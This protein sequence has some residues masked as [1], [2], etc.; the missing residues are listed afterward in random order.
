MNPKRVV[1]I[2]LDPLDPDKTRT[3]TIPLS[4]PVSVPVQ[5]IGIPTGRKDPVI[6]EFPSVPY[7]SP[8]DFPIEADAGTVIPLL[9]KDPTQVPLDPF[10]IKFKPKGGEQETFDLPELKD[11]RTRPKKPIE[12][13]DI[14]FNTREDD[15]NGPLIVEE[16]LMPVPGEEEKMVFKVPKRPKKDWKN[17]NPLTCELPPK[18]ERKVPV[19][20]QIPTVPSN[21]DETLH[22]F[23]PGALQFY[24]PSTTGE[25]PLKIIFAPT[26]KDAI[27]YTVQCK[28][29]AGKKPADKTKLLKEETIFQTPS[30]RTISFL[31]TQDPTDPTAPKKVNALTFETDKDKLIT[32]YLPDKMDKDTPN[33]RLVFTNPDNEEQYIFEFPVGF[34]GVK[35]PPLKTPEGNLDFNIFHPVTKEIKDMPEII[36]LPKKAK[37][38]FN[39][40]LPGL[41]LEGH[42]KDQPTTG[43]PTVKLFRVSFQNP[44]NKLVT[45]DTLPD[46]AQPDGQHIVQKINFEMDGKIESLSL[47]MPEEGLPPNSLRLS[48]T[49]AEGNQLVYI[50]PNIPHEE[51]TEGTEDFTTDEG[52]LRFDFPPGAEVQAFFTPTSTGEES[53]YVLP[54]LFL[55]GQ[56]IEAASAD[57]KP[58]TKKVETTYQTIDKKEVTFIT[59]GEPPVTFPTAPGSGSDR[60]LSVD[61]DAAA[62]SGPTPVLQLTFIVPGAKKSIVKLGQ[63]EPDK[64][65]LELVHTKGDET[66]VYEFPGLPAADPSEGAL[67]MTYKWSNAKVTFDIPSQY[68][69]FRAGVSLIL[70]Q[71]NADELAYELPGFRL[72]G[73]VPKTKPVTTTVTFDTEDDQQVTFVTASNPEVNNIHRIMSAM[74]DGEE[75]NISV[76]LAKSTKGLAGLGAEWV[77]LKFTSPDDDIMNFQIPGVP[78]VGAGARQSITLPISGGMVV[79][80]IPQAK[81][82]DPDEGLEFLV[83]HK[84]KEIKY[85]LPGFTQ[86]LD[87]GE[88]AAGAVAAGAGPQGR[89]MQRGT[90]HTY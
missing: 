75:K 37:K 61:A 52:T 67:R 33:L 57:A 90:T 82:Q 4:T 35:N 23:P 81:S 84:G 14:T 83:T 54:G 40:E 36:F 50:F 88:P 76:P 44:D 62:A 80:N 25:P 45:F 38:P 65:Y 29:I 5:V 42:D 70:K 32:A 58:K 49:S 13:D 39:Y 64:K 12:A 1:E 87:S 71:G 28:R 19:I 53:N 77:E 17:P 7:D 31:T 55:E 22:P 9:P 10:K 21:F 30:E 68:D 60:P 79:L 6:L 26:D 86:V 74:F 63:K 20:I 46:P 59:V 11:Y 56:T 34:D 66:V 73:A 69:K 41:S 78:R 15:P 2:I 51:G 3:I 16:I 47:T 18:G 27:P 89:S 72:K 48:Y 8:L 85:V 43:K 24:P